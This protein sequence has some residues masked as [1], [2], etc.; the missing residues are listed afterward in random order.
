MANVL[1]KP[2]GTQDLFGDSK[3]LIDGI[4]RELDDVAARF[5]CQK[6]DGPI[7]EEEALFVRGVGESS[8]IV[9][10]EMFRLDVKGEHAYVLRPEFTASIN[11]MVIENK[12]YASPDLPLRISYC[13][14][15]FR[16]E[17]PQAGRYREFHQWGVEFLDNKI[18]LN[19]ALDA[20]LL[21]YRAGE[22]LFGR[23]LLLKLNYLGGS[24]SRKAYQQALKDFYA[25]KVGNMCDDCKR[26]FNQNVLRILDCKVPEDIEINKAA[27]LIQDYLVEEDKKTFEQIKETLDN[28]KVP[29]KIDARL[30]RGLDYYTGVVFELYD[31]MNMDLGAIGGGGQYGNLM[32]ELGGPAFEGIGFSFG[33][34][35]LMLSLDEEKRKELIEKMG[36]QIDYFFIDLRKNK[37]TLPLIVEDELRT[38]G[39][40]VAACSYAKALSGA[41]KMADR[42]HAKTSLIFDDYNPNCVIIKDMASR[43]QEIVPVADPEKVV[44]YLMN[45]EK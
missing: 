10:K 42:Y 40:N 43:E 27:P 37:D 19:S 22:E 20:M 34:E 31:P 23:E 25:P 13:G 26:R 12:M 15:V 28:L 7:F 38:A 17:R 8:D 4:E 36:S 45:K 11:R 33:V 30:V 41:L 44:S 21:M 14:P 2:R 5:A 3:K 16:F 35:R 29:Y 9:S 32:A 39:R 1:V 24:E 6:A 18:D